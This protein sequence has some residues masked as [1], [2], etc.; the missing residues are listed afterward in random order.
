MTFTVCPTPFFLAVTTPFLLTAAYFLLETDHVI[1]LLAAFDGVTVAFNFSFLEY[2]RVAL[3]LFSL[4]FFTFTT[5]EAF[6][7]FILL[8]SRIPPVRKK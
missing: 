8:R 5:G 7:L 6:A 3:F 4:T 1:V 2:E